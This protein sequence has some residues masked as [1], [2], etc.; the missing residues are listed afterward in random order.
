[1]KLTPYALY[2]LAKAKTPEQRQ[3]EQNAR[4]DAERE[5]ENARRRYRTEWQRRRRA[6]VI[7]PAASAAPT[8]PAQT[9]PSGHSIRSTPPRTPSTAR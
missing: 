3:A 4:W 7:T 2:V 5:R 8:P 1:M 6:A 9:Q